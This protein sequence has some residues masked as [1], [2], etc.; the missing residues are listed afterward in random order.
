MALLSKEM[1][2][3]SVLW[4]LVLTF[5]HC[6][7]IPKLINLMKEKVSFG[8]WFQRLQSMVTWSFG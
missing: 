2:A 3:P 8:L 7:K 4:I 5:C 6:D 1:T